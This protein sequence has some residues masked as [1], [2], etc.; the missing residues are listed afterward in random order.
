MT[1]E[2]NTAAN[3]AMSDMSSRCSWLAKSRAVEAWTADRAAAARVAPRP[4]NTFCC[5]ASSLPKRTEC[6]G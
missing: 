6:V 1:M 3:V 2:G 4:L 5:R